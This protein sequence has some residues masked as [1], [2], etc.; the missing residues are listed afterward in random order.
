MK[1]SV[2]GLLLQVWSVFLMI[3]FIVGFLAGITVVVII[4]LVLYVHKKMEE[5]L[6]DR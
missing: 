6:K 4:D 5:I 3:E 1:K 2:T